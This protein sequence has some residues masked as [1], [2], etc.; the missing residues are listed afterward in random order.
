MESEAPSHQPLTLRCTG[1]TLHSCGTFVTIDEP[2]L[3]HQYCVVYLNIPSL[4]Q[5]SC[6]VCRCAMRCVA[7]TESLQNRNVLGPPTLGSIIYLS[8]LRTLGNH[9]GFFFIIITISIVFLGLVY[10]YV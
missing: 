7:F 6:E 1:H 8:P 2:I 3:T 10:E 5:A 4:D 9:R